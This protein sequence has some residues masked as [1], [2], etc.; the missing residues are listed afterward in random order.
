MKLYIQNAAE[1]IELDPD[2]KPRFTAYTR[3][4]SFK[5]KYGQDGSMQTGDGRVASRQ[6]TLSYYGKVDYP[7]GYDPAV[8]GRLPIL[9]DESY[10]E[11]IEI[12]NCFFRPDLSPFYLIDTDNSIRTQIEMSSNTDSPFADGTELRIGANMM[13]LEMLSGHWEDST[14]QTHNETGLISSDTFEINNTARLEAYPVLE[15]TALEA[16]SLLTITNNTNGK[17]FSISSTALVTGSVLTIDP[18]GNDGEGSI[19]INDVDVST[20]IDEDSGFLTLDHGVNEF[21]YEATGQADLEVRWR[22]RYTI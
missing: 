3:R 16:I 7:A 17:Q 21:L 6:I 5:P 11:K 15:F 8:D 10:R 19:S 20:S 22:R 18:F 4:K 1:T 9:L 12:L 13:N 14:E 2:F